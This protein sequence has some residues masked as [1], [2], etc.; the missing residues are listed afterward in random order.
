MLR[1]HLGTV[2]GNQLW[3][4]EQGAKLANLKPQ[5]FYDSVILCK[6]AYM[7]FCNT[8]FIKTILHLT[9][10]RIVSITVYDHTNMEI[11]REKNVSISSCQ[12][13]LVSL[14]S[15]YIFLKFPS[16]NSAPFHW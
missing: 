14:F 5:P 13:K 15:F 9:Q 3:L 11:D 4:A 10:N 2:L 7:L 1:S 12:L 6:L 8:N 16:A